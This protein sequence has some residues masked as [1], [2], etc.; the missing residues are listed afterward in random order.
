MPGSSRPSFD[1]QVT[2]RRHNLLGSIRGPFCR[3]SLCHLLGETSKCMLG[4]FFN[5]L[6]CCFKKKKCTLKSSGLGG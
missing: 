5:L 3:Q 6:G 2:E 1:Y 4:F